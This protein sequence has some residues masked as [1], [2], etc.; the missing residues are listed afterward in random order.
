MCNGIYAFKP[1][2]RRIPAGG[3]AVPQA[4]PNECFLASAGS[5]ANDFEALELLMRHV[6]DAH[7]S[8]SVVTTID[9]PW[10]NADTTKPRLC[11]GLVKELT[12]YLLHPPVKTHD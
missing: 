12:D 11:L 8:H 3:Q 7:P 6:I 2:T 9:I 4:P 10:R 1:S 5:L